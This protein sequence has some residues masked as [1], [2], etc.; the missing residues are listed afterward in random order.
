MFLYAYISKKTMEAFVRKLIVLPLIS[1]AL[2]SA[3]MMMPQVLVKTSEFPIAL[4]YT[5]ELPP[6][7]DSTK[8]YPLVVGIHGF[9]DRMSSYV[10]TAQTLVP[11]GAIGLYPES[12]YPLSPME[13][14]ERF[15]W[16]W[17]FWSD[18][19]EPSFVSNDLT[20]D[21]SVRW[22][23]AAIEKVEKEYPVDHSK[24]FL[25]GFSQG[26]YLTYK[27][28]LAY[29]ELFRGLL[30]AGGWMDAD[31]LHPLLLP[32]AALKLPVRI[33]HG[34]YDNVVEYKSAESAYDT[35]KDRDMAVELMRYPV[36]HQLANEEF[37][38]ARDFI[39]RE[40]NPDTTPL[41]SLLWP[42]E[43]LS[44]DDHAVFLHKVLCSSAP[45]AD[46]EAG[47]L[48]LYEEDTSEVVRKEIIYLLGARRCTGAELALTLILADK[49][50]PQPLRQ[51]SYSALIKLATESAWKTV[52]ATPKQ[53]VITDVIPGG[54]GEAVGLQ[55]RDVVL[56]YN[57]HK[58]TTNTELRD[59][60]NSV[61]P[62]TKSV[63]ML[64]ERGGKRMK[65]KL[66]PGR[67]GIR[68]AEEIK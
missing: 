11:D 49:T 15:G 2:L 17:W 18:T 12:A 34:A 39:F 42:E 35:L 50:Q 58:I 68:L 13:E 26:G 1:V 22:I 10:G 32:D 54:Q 43:A 29:P 67:I 31:S 52:D 21:Q 63:I 56:S 4:G 65:I 7:F 30:P 55:A 24:V 64:V 19:T 6:N 3:Q 46:I 60:L 57:N 40:L 27:V 33:L 48:K 28:G 8:T 36:K 53:L 45:L 37:E 51:A 23:A 9:G 61:K 66:A 16:T 14:G 38:D 59:A 41:I 5:V 62:E 47:L 44:P 20:L 25:F